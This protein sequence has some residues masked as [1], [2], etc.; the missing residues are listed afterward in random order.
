MFS[1]HLQQLTKAVDNSTYQNK[2]QHSAGHLSQRCSSGTIFALQT[3][4][5]QQT[6]TGMTAC[7]LALASSTL[8]CCW[9]VNV[10]WTNLSNSSHWVA[11]VCG[12]PVLALAACQ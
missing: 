7:H 9:T 11:P 1:S 8:C 4:N 3:T 10:V 5:I 6:T 12:A 2:Q